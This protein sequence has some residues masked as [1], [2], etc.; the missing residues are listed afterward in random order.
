MTDVYQRHSDYINL[1]ATDYLHTE[2]DT[3]HWCLAHLLT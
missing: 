3:C 1:F 2:N